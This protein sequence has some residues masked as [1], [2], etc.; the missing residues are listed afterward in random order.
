[1]LSSDHGVDLI[2][3]HHHALHGD[4][5]HRLDDRSIST[6]EDHGPADADGMRDAAPETSTL[7]GCHAGRHRPDRMLE[8]V[9]TALR[10]RFGISRDLAIEFWNPSIYLD[11]DGIRQL[12]LDIIEVEEFA[13]DVLREIPGIARVFPRNSLSEGRGPRDPIAQMVRRSFHPDRSGHL[14]V[15]QEPAWYLHPEWSKYAAMHGSPYA[16]DTHVPILVV[17][18]D[19]SAGTIY[20]RVGPEDIASTLAMIL[21]VPIPSGSDGD[22]LH[23][24]LGQ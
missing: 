24:I 1:V 4:S 9:N 20:R 23:E 15:I 8:L 21:E 12:Q 22:P 17:S 10:D 19:I 3:E 18:P 16:Y 14:L 7:D 5:K 2:P 6:V 11:E 13:A